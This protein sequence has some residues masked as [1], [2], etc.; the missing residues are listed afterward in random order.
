MPEVSIIIATYNA[1]KVLERCL[2]SVFDQNCTD[3][4]VIIV[5]GGSTDDTLKIVSRFNIDFVISEVDSG[6]YDAWNKGLEISKGKW[7]MFL[8]SDDLLYNNAICIYKNLFDKIDVSQID[9][10]HSCIS[11]V[12]I[13]GE[14]MRIKGRKWVW[15][16]FK[17][18][19]T[20]SHVGS[21][22][23]RNYFKLYGNFDTSYKIAGDYEL[24]LRAKSTLSTFYIDNVIGEMYYGGIST[25][26]AKALI[27]AARAKLFTAN[28]S[29][30]CVVF[31][32]LLAYLKY[33]VKKICKYG[34]F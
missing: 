7:I 24:L 18:Y 15:H 3:F 9:V 30:I 22:H 2:T 11:L 1:E 5:D 21:L 26:N 14:Y 25:A 4:E 6:V 16:E 34:L 20:I 27:E 12:N 33:I 8:G 32:F 10:I 19:M 17:R 29:L 23:N 28:I 13:R 31:D